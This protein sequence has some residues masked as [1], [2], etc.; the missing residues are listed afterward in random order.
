MIKCGLIFYYILPLKFL[1]WNL[2]FGRFVS[3]FFNLYCFTLKLT[4]LTSITS[5]LIQITT[6]ITSSL[7]VISTIVYQ[8]QTLRAG[9]TREI[10]W[11]KLVSSFTFATWYHKIQI[12]WNWKSF[13]FVINKEIRIIIESEWQPEDWQVL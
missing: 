3:P 13:W 10:D 6:E 12:C 11:S 1:I 7:Q 2:I 5:K 8:T 9:V 4:F